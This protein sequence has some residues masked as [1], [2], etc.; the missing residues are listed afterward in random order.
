MRLANNDIRL[1][2]IDDPVSAWDAQ[3]ERDLFNKFLNMHKG[4]TTILAT[5]RFSDITQHADLIMCVSTFVLAIL[6]VYNLYGC[7]AS[8]MDAG[9][10]AERG[11]HEELMHQN[12]VYSKLYKTQA[13]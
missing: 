5:H 7:S 10:I 11:T 2:V 8:R 3:A 1:L 13:V 12:G 4:K 6:E 9:N